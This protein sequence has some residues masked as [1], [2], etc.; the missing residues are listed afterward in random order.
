MG[1][2]DKPRAAHYFAS[3]RY[4][5]SDK[6][7]KFLRMRPASRAGPVMRRLA[8]RFEHIFIDEIQDMAGYDL[9]VLD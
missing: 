3:G 4:I 1:A 8:Q 9:D 5:Y 2:D 7:S 6:I